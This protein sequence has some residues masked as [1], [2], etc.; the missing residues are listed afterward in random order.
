MGTQMI[1]RRLFVAGGLAALPVRLAASVPAPVVPRT[2]RLVV[3]PS[4]S[5][6]MT[7]WQPSTD[8]LKGVAL[9]STGHGSWPARYEVLGGLL[10]SHGF[11]VLA[12]MHVDSVRHP[13][14]ASFTLQA[15][16]GERIA[17]MAAAS[18]HA[19]KVFPGQP[20]VAV[21]HS[22]GTLTSLC[23]VGAL[24]YLGDFRD[25]SVKAVLGFSSPGRIPGLVQPVAYAAVTA[26]LML[27][28]GTADVVPGFVT[29][30]ADHLL[31][32]ETVKGPAFGLV[33]AGADHEFVGQNSPGI[34]G[35]D[36]PIAAFLSAYALNDRAA[37]MRLVAYKPATGDRY[38]VRNAR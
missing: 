11:A 29:D 36:Q 26:P 35:I 30:P 17:D 8:R 9:L 34:W 31:P 33:K 37:A 28:T 14:R 3:T 22:F 18:A 13:D 19:G 5:T 12:P 27:V 2:E 1:D 21:G 6:E 4:R 15:S 10:S 16:F 25:P 23:R 38:I 20:V 32:V 7:V 24:G